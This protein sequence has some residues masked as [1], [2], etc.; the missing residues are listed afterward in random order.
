MNVAGYNVGVSGEIGLKAEAGFQIGKDG[1]E[2]KLPLFS[3]GINFGKA[4]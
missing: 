2:I 4:K 1:V 3:F